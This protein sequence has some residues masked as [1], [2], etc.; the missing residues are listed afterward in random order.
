MEAERVFR[1]ST[2]VV[3]VD[4]DAASSH[5]VDVGTSTGDATGDATVAPS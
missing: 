1:C 3:R 2:G 5:R 4:E